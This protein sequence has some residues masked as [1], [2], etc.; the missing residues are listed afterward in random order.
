[1][2][3]IRGRQSGNVPMRHH[4]RGWRARDIRSPHQDAGPGGHPSQQRGCV[5]RQAGVGRTVRR[6]LARHRDQLQGHYA[7]YL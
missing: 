7:V 3:E 4:G 6:L 1:M 5:T 2:P